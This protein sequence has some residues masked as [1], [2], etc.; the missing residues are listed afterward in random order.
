LL[1]R[2][3]IVEHSEER[4]GLHETNRDPIRVLGPLFSETVE[5]VESDLV[6]R[7]R[8]AAGYLYSTYRISVFQFTDTLLGAY[9]CNFNLIPATP[10]AEQ[11]AEFFYRSVVAV[12]SLT[13][14]Q[15]Q[16]LKSGERLT[17][18]KVFSLTVSG[19]SQIR[20]VLDDPAIRAGVEIRSLGDSAAA[21]IRAMVR[22]Y[23]APLEDAS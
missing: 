8:V 7:R 3:R 21:N 23:N 11:T 15:T 22:Q 14:T 19:G 1:L 20:I 5:G 17:Q 12:R 6:L 2:G 13:E 16:V 18:S 9:Q 10:A 4:L